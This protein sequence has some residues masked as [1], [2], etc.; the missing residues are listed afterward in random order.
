MSDLITFTPHLEPYK[1]QRH[2]AKQLCFQLNSLSPDQKSERKALLSKL[3]PNA[4]NIIVES[5]FNCDFGTNIIAGKGVFFNHHVTVL[6]SASVTIGNNV[7]V[8]PHTVISATTHPKDTELRRSG[9]QYASPIQI[10][11]D[12]WIGASVTI[13]PGVIIGD[14]AIIAAGAVVVKDVPAKTTFIK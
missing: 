4:K 13:L 9:V 8:G 3:L 2:R 11:H 6:D 14:E 10:G 1:S 12:V 5:G 7:L